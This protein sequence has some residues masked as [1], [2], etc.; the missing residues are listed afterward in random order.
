MQDGDALLFFSL[1]ARDENIVTM[2]YIVLIYIGRMIFI[3]INV[4]I[5]FCFS[6]TEK[7]Y[8]L[9]ASIICYM[10]C[11]CSLVSRIIIVKNLRTL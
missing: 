11:S 5:F 7:P 6:A 8:L 9:N 10:L 3:I 1:V 2:I 4:P